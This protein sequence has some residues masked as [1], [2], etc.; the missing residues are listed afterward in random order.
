[1]LLP[2]LGDLSHT[3]ILLLPRHITTSEFLN[4]VDRQIAKTKKLSN[5]TFKDLQPMVQTQYS[6]EQKRS[7]TETKG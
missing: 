4:N 3:S 6:P 2:P 7:I 1:M 5:I